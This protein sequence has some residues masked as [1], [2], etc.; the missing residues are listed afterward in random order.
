MQIVGQDS[1]Q[2]NTQGSGREAIGGNSHD[3]QT[4]TARLTRPSGQ[5]M[6]AIL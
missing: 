3:P 6:G 4:A 1:V 5:A 2:I